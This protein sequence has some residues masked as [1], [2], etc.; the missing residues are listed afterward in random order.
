MAEVEIRRPER[1]D[2]GQLFELVRD[3]VTSFPADESA[4]A[5]SFEVLLDDP[6]CDLLCA[7]DGAEM[8]GYVLAFRHPT[9]F[10]NGPVAWVEELHVRP[11]YRRRGIAAALMRAVESRAR[12]HGVRL[13]A[14]ATR[15]ADEFYRA[16]GYEE[17]ATYYRRVLG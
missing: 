17:S 4:F 5:R 1:A 7:F 12:E 6:G 14:L 9:F 2:G 10:A 8:T 3:F 15:R 16:I 11:E 13:V